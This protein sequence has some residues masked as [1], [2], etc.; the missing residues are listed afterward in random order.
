L[1]VL[2][3]FDKCPEDTCGIAMISNMIEEILHIDC[4]VMMG[5]NIAIE[6][7]REEFCETT[8]GMCGYWV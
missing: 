8:I 1:N 3:G 5:A 6:V 2:Q 4:C 7:A